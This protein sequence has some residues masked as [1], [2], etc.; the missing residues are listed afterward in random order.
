MTAAAAGAGARGG[1]ARARRVG[2]TEGGMTGAGANRGGTGAAAGAGAETA[3]ATAKAGGIEAAA[4]IAGPTTAA[5]T[6]LTTD[7]VRGPAAGMSE[8]SKHL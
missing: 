4:E 2:K 7:D 1:T 6:V 8:G 5:E 3:A